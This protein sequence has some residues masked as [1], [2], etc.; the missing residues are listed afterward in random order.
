MRLL[1]FGFAMFVI[2]ANGVAS[3]KPL[4]L[5]AFGGMGGSAGNP[6]GMDGFVFNA[7]NDGGYFPDV[8]V[9]GV[10]FAS[11]QLQ[12]DIQAM[13]GLHFKHV[14][15][16]YLRVDLGNVRAGWTAA[17]PDNTAWQTVCRNVQLAAAAAQQDGAEGLMLDTEMYGEYG[18][19][20]SI[21]PFRYSA[22]SQ[23]FQRTTM[24]DDVAA[25]ARVRGRQF[26]QA[27]VAGFPKA[28]IWF[29]YATSAALPRNPNEPISVREFNLLPA[30][31]DGMMDAGPS[32]TNIDGYEA[33]YQFQSAAQF[34]DAQRLIVSTAAALSA[35]P[36]RYQ[37]L[38][39][40][41]FGLW[42]SALGGG[43]LGSNPAQNDYTPAQLTQALQYAF[44]YGDGYIWLY[45]V[46]WLNHM[47]AAY[48]SVIARFHSRPPS[49]SPRHVVVAPWTPPAPPDKR[50]FF[51]AKQ[52][53]I[54][55]PTPPGAA[56]WI[57]TGDYVSLAAAGGD[58]INAAGSTAFSPMTGQVIPDG[59]YQVVV[60]VMHSNV[61]MDNSGSPPIARNG[62]FSYSLTLKRGA[63]GSLS[64]GGGASSSLIAY[65]PQ[66]PDGTGEGAGGCVADTHF[67]AYGP[68]SPAGG[69][70]GFIQLQGSV[71]TSDL[72]F[73]LRD[74]VSLNYG[75]VGIKS[76][77]LVPIP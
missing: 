43:P 40:I 64:F 71:K 25:Q 31:I 67:V 34:A 32:N 37:R 27:I 70:V 6:T 44:Q 33:S 7:T 39:K 48:S 61:K 42:P 11:L 74:D 52:A 69:G 30:F 13:Q 26:M 10:S 45:N 22:Q 50:W 35:D 16:N 60:D 55:N 17:E 62:S 47:P 4:D 2:I 58:A 38:M 46:P 59:K 28:K 57:Y 65:Y 56:N 77:Q 19:T 1:Y 76:F 24:F 73:T 36:P 53:Q 23:D 5:I 54:G 66:E 15:R 21:A 63:V 41:G 20:V 51:Y 49:Q 8:S 3:T 14:T 72:V 68:S 12:G 18:R 29:T 75:C 9:S